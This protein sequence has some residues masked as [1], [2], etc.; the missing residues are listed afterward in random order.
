MGNTSYLLVFKAF[1][2]GNRKFKVTQTVTIFI[3]L[4]H[5]TR[6]SNITFQIMRQIRQVINNF[7]D[8][9]PTDIKWAKTNHYFTLKN[10]D[11]EQLFLP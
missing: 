7:T 8:N 11:F 2:G 6:V 4:L 1:F 5:K 3:I 9:L 10:V